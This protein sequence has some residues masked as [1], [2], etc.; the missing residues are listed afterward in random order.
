MKLLVI[1]GTKFVGR[2]LVD[3]AMKAGHD[4]MLFNRGKTDPELFPSVEKIRGDRVRDI[5]ALGNQT[6]DCVIDTC[7]YK[8]SEVRASAQFLCDKVERYFFIS[9]VSAYKL[10]G[11][12]S[13]DEDSA[14][15]P[16]AEGQIAE[17]DSLETYGVRKALCEL[18]LER[19]MPGRACT[20]RPTIIAGPYDPS[21]RFT[22]WVNRI[23]RGGEVL[24]PGS[25]D[26]PV[27]YI[28][29]RDLAQWILTLAAANQTGSFNAACRTITMSEFLGSFVRCLNRD[30]RLT[31][32]DDRFL[33]SLEFHFPFWTFG[34][35]RTNFK[36]NNRKAVQSGLA[37]RPIAE[38]IFDVNAWQASDKNNGL[39]KI[40]ISREVESSLLKKWKSAS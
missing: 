23:A 36:A 34:I 14:L 20:I 25:P 22:Y 39:D 9:S 11:A 15:A 24:A 30:A 17:D 32:V 21:G 13:L 26:S 2:H 1:G 35:W 27:Q 7:G 6:W 3:A 10:E 33:E 8:P 40:G 5:A 31:W 4:I 28:D 37:F 16:L 18:E 38:S 19:I 29:A 12:L